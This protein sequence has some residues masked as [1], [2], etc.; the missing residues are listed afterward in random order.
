MYL[1]Q[2]KVENEGV[3]GT[4]VEL[5]AAASLLDTG[6]YVY[7]QVGNLYKWHKFSKSMVG[8]PCKKSLYAIYICNSNGIHYD[9]V[10]KRYR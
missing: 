3:W 6:I 8:G 1:G 2:T 9:V 10:G 4:D 7:T 5:L